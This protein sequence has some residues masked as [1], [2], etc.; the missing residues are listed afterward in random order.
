MLNANNDPSCENL[1]VLTPF[2]SL[3]SLGSS[4][5]YFIVSISQMQ[6]KGFAPISPEAIYFFPGCI[7]KAVMSSLWSVK[8]TCLLVSG[9]STIPTAAAW[10]T[11]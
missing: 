10:Y 1:I 5:I 7:A 3:A 4:F 11:I 9:L 2:I 6:A 8:N